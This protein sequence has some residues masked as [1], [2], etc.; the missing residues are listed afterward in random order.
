MPRLPACLA[1][2][3]LAGPVS[4]Q[5][6]EPLLRSLDPLGSSF[7]SDFRQGFVDS[8]GHWLSLVS[9]TTLAQALV[10][11]GTVLVESGDFL[12]SLSDSVLGFAAIGGSTRNLALALVMVST[13]APVLGRGQ[14]WFRL[15][16]T[17]DAAGL[18]PGTV[19]STLFALSA[20][21]HDRTLALLQVDS[22]E[23]VLVSLTFRAGGPP[24]SALELITGQ[25]LADGS[26]LE[27]FELYPFGVPLN[28]RGEWLLAVRASDGTERLLTPGGTVLRTGAP[29]PLPGRSV[30]DL[31]EWHDLN[32]LGGYAALVRLSGDPATDEL[33]IVNSAKLAQEG[34]VLPALAPAALVELGDTLRCTDSGPVFW[35][36]RTNGPAG[37]N[38]AY[39]R[40][41][42]PFL[43]SGVSRIAGRLVTGL[44]PGNGSYEVSADG[45]FWLGRVDVESLRRLLVRADFGAAVPLPGCT[46]NAGTL[47]HTGGLVLSGA[48]IELTLDGPVAPGALASVQFSLGAAGPGDC[49]IA[50]PFGELL[51]DPRRRV[52]ALAA[53][54]FASAPIAVPL[55]LP[56]DPALVD[57][58]L[59]AQG[60]FVAPG[61]LTLT[62]GLRLVVGAP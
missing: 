16:Q 10:Q 55:A 6:F 42:E 11:D 22:G 51:I 39:M 38:E 50:T 37:T 62:N 60:A 34:D 7:L 12:P 14:V 59:F 1:A 33:L 3:L 47:R 58:E 41:R 32:D 56:A 29:S 18:P 35:H 25:S 61:G 21:E 24:L 20:N 5:G 9:E 36:A 52:G 31:L 48:T 17:I 46:P 43:R 40:D 4:A 23:V 57:L 27:S 2:V 28:E 15:G 13:G 19:A 8:R 49:G 45:R 26:V 44:D 30:V 53:G 54:I